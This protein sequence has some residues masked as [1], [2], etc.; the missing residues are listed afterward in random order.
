MQE[1][2]GETFLP[3]YWASVKDDIWKKENWNFSDESMILAEHQ[4]P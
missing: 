2:I 1:S 3:V 4:L